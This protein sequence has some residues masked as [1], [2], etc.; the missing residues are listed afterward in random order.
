MAVIVGSERKRPAWAE[1]GWRGNSPATRNLTN[2]YLGRFAVVTR[3]FAAVIREA[4]ADRTAAPQSGPGAPIVRCSV[5]RVL[6]G[7]IGAGSVAVG[8]V[9]YAVPRSA[10]RR[11]GIQ[12]GSDPSSTIMM[13]GAG[14]RDLITGLALVYTAA[15]DG[16]YRPWLAMRAAADA[17]DALAGG[18][19]LTAHT[20]SAK[21][22]RTT[23]SA[24]LLS[25]A[26]FL[27]WSA[28][29]QRNH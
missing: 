18:L 6:A 26:E 16:N 5:T 27:L 8:A 28:S 4:A 13:R 15:C 23:F 2:A 22:A 7:A 19:S 17:A 10:A 20:A 29:A 24:L 9:Q 12:L 14:A 11:F 25:G 3:G 21:Q 1:S